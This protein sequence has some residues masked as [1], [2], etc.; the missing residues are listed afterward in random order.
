MHRKGYK[1]VS[2]HSK[3]QLLYLRKVI[4]LPVNYADSMMGLGHFLSKLLTFTNADEEFEPHPS[5]VTR[6][7]K[8]TWEYNKEHRNFHA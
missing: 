8:V 7:G 4:F 1:L 3:R 6:A 2:S 5:V